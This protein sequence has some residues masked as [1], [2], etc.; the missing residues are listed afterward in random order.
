MNSNTIPKNKNG[1]Q[2]NLLQTNIDIIDAQHKEII[3]L[4]DKLNE[5]KAGNVDFV[6]VSNILVELYSCINFHFE[7][8]ENLMTSAGVTDTEKHVQQHDF[9]RSKLDEFRKMNVTKSQFLNTLNF[10]LF[11]SFLRNWLITHFYKFDSEYV[12]PVAAHIAATEAE[13]KNRGNQ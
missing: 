9:F 11:L 10:E 13:Q 8:E 3:E 2:N 12:I 4:F 5:Q 7:T 1:K 6:A